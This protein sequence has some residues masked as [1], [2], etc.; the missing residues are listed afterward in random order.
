MTKIYSIDL[1]RNHINRISQSSRNN[2]MDYY[3]NFILV[4]FEWILI[5]QKWNQNNQCNGICVYLH[6]LNLVLFEFKF[7][8]QVLIM[9]DKLSGMVVTC[10]NMKDM[11]KDIRN[12]K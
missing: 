2:Y 5:N 7:I 8:S 11:S 4:K 12:I 6:L 3:C 10:T 9:Y 1:D